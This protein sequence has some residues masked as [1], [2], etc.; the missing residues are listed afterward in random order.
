MTLR[1]APAAGLRRD[2]AAAAAAP[3]PL[4]AAPTYAPA[5]AGLPPFGALVF[6]AA[7]QRRRLLERPVFIA[8]ATAPARS[9]SSVA[10]RAIVACRRAKTSRGSGRSGS[11]PA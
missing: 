6:S 7:V 11:R 1:T 4:P 3:L 10:P 9:G 5:P 8:W 2:A